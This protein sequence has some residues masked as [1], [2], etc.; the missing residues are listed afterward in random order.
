MHTRLLIIVAIL[1]VAFNLLLAAGMRNLLERLLLRRRLREVL[2]LVI[3][4][5]GLLPQLLI[6]F[7]VT[8]QA[9]TSNLPVAVFWPWAAT[10][11]LML[12]LSIAPATGITLAYLA[13]AYVFSRYQF[14]KGIRADAGP[15]V[16]DRL[17]AGQPQE[18]MVGP[19]HPAAVAIALGPARRSGPKEIA[20]ADPVA[21]FPPRLHHGLF[22][23]AGG[24]AAHGIAQDSGPR[25]GVLMDA[26]S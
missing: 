9:L 13:L 16:A 25:I 5:A 12:Q 10:A 14:E 4:F 1:F 24:L 26:C 22:F 2:M 7:K 15:G 21:P 8:N 20:N 6:S 17:Q 19:T 23:R 18:S 11:H 3:V